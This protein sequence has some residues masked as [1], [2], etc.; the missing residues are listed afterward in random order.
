MF[1]RPRTG[2]AYVGG[3][4]LLLKTRSGLKLYVDSRDV[5]ISPHLILD[6]VWEEWTE[7]VLLRSLRRGMT[8]IEVGANIGYFTLTMGRAVGPSGRVHAFE[9]DPELAQLARDN[10]EINGLQRWVSVV[11][12]AVGGRNGTATFYRASRHR[13]G[14]SLIAGLEQNPMMATDQHTPFEVP[15]TTLDSF[16]AQE[17]IEPDLVKLDAEGAEPSILRAS[18][19]LLASKRALTIVMEFFPRFVR[20]AGDDPASLLRLITERGFTIE[21]IDEKRRRSQPATIDALLA[22]ESSELVIKRMPPA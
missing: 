7:R 5:S 18:P 1:D 11:Q 12:R 4:R 15:M 6:G 17:R 20:E 14:G 19:V 3:N 2:A 21:A 13:G 22:R 8:V 9:C 16:V 10:V